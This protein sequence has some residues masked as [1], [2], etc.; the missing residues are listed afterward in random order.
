MRSIFQSLPGS[1]SRLYRQ[2]SE[3]YTD[4]DKLK[5]RSDVSFKTATCYDDL[6]PAGTK[7]DPICSA[8][9][10]TVWPFF[11]RCDWTAYL[12]LLRFVTLKSAYSAFSLVHVT[13]CIMC[14]AWGKTIPHH[15]RRISQVLSSQLAKSAG[16]WS[17]V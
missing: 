12:L 2:S 9:F 17:A 1:S 7:C 16:R 13:Y 10:R 15:G 8:H 6:G 11:V 4:R 3:S 14:S 5:T